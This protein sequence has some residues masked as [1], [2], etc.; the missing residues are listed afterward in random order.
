VGPVFI[1]QPDAGFLVG[2]RGSR[3]LNDQGS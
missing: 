3:A 2:L 1:A